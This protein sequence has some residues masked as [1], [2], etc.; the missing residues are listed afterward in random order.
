MSVGPDSRVDLNLIEQTRKHINR[1]VEEIAALSNQDLPPG[2]YF[3]EYLQRVQRALACTAGAVWM[4]TQQG[5]LQLQ[6]QINMRQIGIDASDNHRQRHA[7]L[8]RQV[9]NKG[10]PQ[11][12]HPQSGVEGGGE[13][14]A[15]NPT[16]YVLLIVPIL[17]E[18]QVHGLVEIFQDPGRNPHALQGYLQFLKVVVDLAAGY[19]RNSKLR[20]MSGQQQLWTQLEAFARVVHTSLN[21]TEVAYQVANEGNR[22]TGSDRLSVAQ[23]HGRKTVVEAISGADVVE[24]RSNLVQLQRALFDSVIEWRERLVYSGTRDDTLPPAVLKALDGYLAESN[25]KLLVVLPIRDDREKDSPRPP[26]SALMM[27]CFEPNQAA[28]QMVSRLEVV[29]KHSAPALYNALEHRRI[30]MRFIWMPIAKVQEGLGGKARAIIYSVL[31]ALAVFSVAMVVVP[32]PLKMDAKGQLLPEKREWLFT[33]IEGHVERFLVEPNMDVAKDQ[34]LVEMHGLEL[35][36]KLTDLQGKINTTEAEIKTFKAQINAAPPGSNDRQRIL[37]EIFSKEKSLQALNSLLERYRQRVNAEQLA[38]GHFYLKSPIDGTILNY[39]FKE[40]LS[41]RFVKSSDQLLRIGDKNGPWEIELKIPQKHI[42]QVLQAFD[43]KN[44]KK[45]LEV[46]LL[47]SSDPTRVFKGRLSRDKIAGE[48][49]PNRDDN[50]ESEPVVIATVRIEGNDI[51]SADRLPRGLLLTGT[52]VHAKV[53]CG[54]RAMGYSLFY[55]VWEFFYEKVV[56]FF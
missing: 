51:P 11:I 32:Y 45:E 9:V 22:L 4:F 37:A 21:P 19:I 20:Q 3:N 1:L 17:I 31:A 39:D 15:G 55:G 30:P 29:G 34:Y 5:H 33:P 8:L 12:M 25:S 6:F 52:E 13:N 26:R 27:E 18:K 16:D 50:N 7:E 43:P 42:G 41:G 10:Q 40:T 2:D 14:S 46:D 44:P 53:R 48:A 23:R 56:F 36:Q 47:L 35:A 54:N 24:K 49:L 28:E 38:P